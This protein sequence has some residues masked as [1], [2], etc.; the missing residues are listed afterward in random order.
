MVIR[1][2]KQRDLLNKTLLIGIILLL[3][4]MSITPSYAVDNVKKSSTLVSSGNILY[5]GGMGPDNYTRIQDAIDDASSGD[6]V[7]VYD[8][9]SPYYEN[10]FIDKS[11]SLIGEDRETTIINGNKYEDSV[12]LINANFVNISGFTIQNGA[13][14]VKLNTKFCTIVGCIIK[15]NYEDGIYL[16]SSIGS[17]I[18][19]N[20]ITNNGNGICLI[21]SSFIN[22]K[23]NN[24]SLS[25]WVGI[26]INSNSNNNT[27]KDN[28][29]FNHFYLGI[30][31]GSSCSDNI[32]I[33]NKISDIEQDS[34]ILLYKCFNNKIILNNLSSNCREGI[35]IEESYNN[36]IS[37]NTFLG[38]YWQG[39]NLV[40]S[41]ENI[42]TNN[43]ITNSDRGI[44]SYYSYNNKIYHNN[45][46]EN[47]QNAD[48]GY[49]NSW[50]NGYPS[51]G[52]YWDDYTG[53]DNDGDG[54]GDTPYH[55]PGGD[56]EDSYP[57][58]K[59]WRGGNQQPYASTID[60]PKRGKPGINYNYNYVATD[61]DGDY[62]WY[63][64]CWGDKEIIYIYGP[65]PSDE[66]V[67]LSYN[68]S[69]PGTFTISCWVRDIYDEISDITTLEVTMP[70]DKLTS[71]SPL[72]R[73]L[74]Q[75]P[76]AF[77]ILRYFIRGR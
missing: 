16:Y 69:E 23:N 51:G 34:E 77:M 4:F 48:D 58:M 27:I 40:Y 11:I 49:N 1:I 15:S 76:S 56:N 39:I 52:N 28:N 62:V 35:Y 29:I 10:I 60:G 75:F 42:V 54:I 33:N 6:T 38:N 43:N 20:N 7:F 47:I 5:V 25:D 36:I 66:E 44:Y 24:I 73:F 14:G 65:Y 68:W 8:N 21:F 71:S 22:I 12:I 2:D 13:N 50:E 41:N 31:I 26:L 72:L 59:P 3:I 32:I 67:T 17:R 45:L 55:I 64:I 30:I 37:S 46:I 57:L 9:S 63:H 74:E 18:I 70:R 61:P 19:A 53:E